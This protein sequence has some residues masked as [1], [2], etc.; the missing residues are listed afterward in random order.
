MAACLMVASNSVRVASPAWAAHRHHAGR[1]PCG[2]PRRSC[3]LDR[4]RL[5]RPRVGKVVDEE[6]DVAYVLVVTSSR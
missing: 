3:R 4:R 6:V 2:T 1:G 5:G